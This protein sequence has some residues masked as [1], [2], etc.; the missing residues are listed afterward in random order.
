LFGLDRKWLAEGQTGAFDPTETLAAPSNS[1]FD[2]GFRLIKILVCAAKGTAMQRLTQID[3][4][5][6][7]RE[8]SPPCWRTTQCSESGT[9]NECVQN[10]TL[11]LVERCPLPRNE[12][13]LRNEEQ[14]MLIF[15]EKIPPPRRP[16]ILDDS[17]KV[18]AVSQKQED[19][20]VKDI[21]A[22]LAGFSW[23]TG[24]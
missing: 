7:L 17:I 11:V 23:K 1:A 19:Y 16:E 12:E 4:R 14:P 2:A 15:T 13:Q 10:G 24:K 8:L 18:D 20:W 22:N 6:R 21:I 5:A 3:A 9:S